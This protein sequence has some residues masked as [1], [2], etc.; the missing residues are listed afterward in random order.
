MN[1]PQWLTVHQTGPL[2]E[3][4]AP[5]GVRCTTPERALLDAWRFA[6]PS[7][8][9]G[10]LYEALWAGLCTWKQLERELLR[11]QR[12]AGR[13]DLERILGWFACGSTSPLELMARRDVFRGH[14]FDELE[15]Q[16]KLEC[17]SRRIVADALHRR[18]KVVVEFDGAR[19]HATAQAVASDRERD[20]DLA[21]AGY[22]TVRFGWDD[23]A[24]RPA[25]C[26]ERLLKVVAARR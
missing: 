13:R 8:R 11:A 19:F 22:L 23:V 24:G 12:V 26:R 9:R 14:A 21:A 18:A 4:A 25:W 3:Y 20:I 17:G 10:L 6:D 16:V 2:Y 7:D 1:A 15:W 5:R